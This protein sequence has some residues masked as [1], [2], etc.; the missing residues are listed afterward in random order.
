[1]YDLLHDINR[2]SL[3]VIFSL[4]ECNEKKYIDA[5]Y[6]VHPGISNAAGFSLTM[7][8]EM[9]KIIQ[10]FYPEMVKVMNQG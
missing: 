9:K 7:M 2:R 5:Q 6:S 3:Y 1:M 4:N 10:H 8:D